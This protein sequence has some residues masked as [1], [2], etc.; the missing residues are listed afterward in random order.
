MK[1]TNK[2]FLLRPPASYVFYEASSLVFGR[3]QS[4][5]VIFS[6][7]WPWPS[8]EDRDLDMKVT[9]KIFL[10][11]PPASYVFYEASGLIFGRNQSFFVIF[12]FLW[13]WPWHEGHET[14]ILLRP[15]ASY[16]FYKASGLIFGRKQRF[17]VI[18]S[19]LWPW[20]SNEDRDL[21]MK[22]TKKLFCWG[23]WP[24]MYFMR[25]PVSFSEET[26]VFSWFF[27]FYDLD[28]DM[29]VTKKIFLLRPPASY[30]FYE[31]SG[32]IFGRNQ[33]FFVIFSF[34]WPWPSNEGHEK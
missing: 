32:L 17:F 23:L 2:I 14:K 21:D 5:F 25:P 7:L 16:V 20:P 4:F 31:A 10:L 27:R 28:L 11:R 9:K 33:S 3:Y 1:V 13:P 24:H 8:N 18:F 34:L 19:F 6:F 30:V 15:P 12:S 29:K 22:V 26:R